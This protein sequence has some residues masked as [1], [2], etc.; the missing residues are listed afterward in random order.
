MKYKTLKQK[1]W[2]TPWKYDKW[3]QLSDGAD[4]Y[5]L[6]EMYNSF[7]D[8]ESCATLVVHCV[9]NFDAALEA[10][11]RCRQ[12]LDSEYPVTDERHPAN[13]LN[14]TITKLE[15]VNT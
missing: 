12:I 1:T 3:G 15:T 11:R 10:L 4:R 7:G 9:N 13:W 2:P 14:E 5:L 6:G 8:Q